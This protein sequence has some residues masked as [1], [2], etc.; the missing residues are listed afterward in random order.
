MFPVRA[1]V[2]ATVLAWT[3]CVCALASSY[4]ELR[5]RFDA[6]GAGSGSETNFDRESVQPMT[7]ALL[8]RAETAAAQHDAEAV[9]QARRSAAWL[10][11]ESDADRDGAP[12]WG[13]PDAWDAFGDGS[14]N[15]AHLPYLITTSLAADALLEACARPGLLEPMERE[16]TLALLTQI[17][18]AWP[19][20]YSTAGAR[21]YFWYSIHDNDAKFVPNV[22]S[23]FAGVTQRFLH[24]HGSRLDLA[25]RRMIQDRVDAAIRS[26]I[27]LATP[28]QNLPFWPYIA[29]G[30][31]TARSSPNDL[32][33]HVY[34]LWGLEI[35]RQYGGSVAIPWTTETAV[36]SLRSFLR[37]GVVYEYPQTVPYGDEAG[38]ETR[39]APARLWGV[40][41]AIGFAAASGRPDT[42]T[43]FATQLETR[44]AR[45]PYRLTPAADERFYPRH[46][47]HVLWGLAELERN[48]R[49][50]H[51]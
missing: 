4:R 38:K 28:E 1:M 46:I 9:T 25:D 49:R 30:D 19:A 45:P 17:F 33:H 6:N 15:P 44:Y 36:D 3:L 2:G 34:I 11:R 50:A 43:Q 10:L 20:R 18:R 47:A 26:I 5:I 40:G 7:F 37:D 24:Q 13:L 32:V 23:H 22:S 29:E 51:D 35:Y 12:G 14:V 39:E 41:A 48:R 16:K 27:A 8:L 21:T 31:R 42:A